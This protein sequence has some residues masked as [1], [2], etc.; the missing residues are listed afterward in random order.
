[1]I[2]RSRNA[3]SSSADCSSPKHSDRWRIVNCGISVSSKT[4][5]GSG[6]NGWT[7]ITGSNR[8]KRVA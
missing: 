6:K 8:A 5:P 7:K 4:N 2:P 1:M 3:A